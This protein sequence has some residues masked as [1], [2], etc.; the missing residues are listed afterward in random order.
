MHVIG[1]DIGTTGVKS[2]LLNEDGALEAEAT[3]GY[4]IHSPKTN[5]FE[6]NPEDWWAAAESSIRQILSSSGARRAKV[7]GIGL[8]GQY[9]GLVLLDKAGRLLRPCILWNDQRTHEEARE[10][11]EKVGGSR[12][13]EIACTRGA[14]YFTACKLLWVRKHEPELYARA[15]KMLLPKDYIRYRLTGE[16]ATDVS[17]ASGTIL[18]NVAR[19]KW[20]PELCGALDI[21]LNFLPAVH[22]SC[23]PT[24]Q[25]SASISRELGLD[26]G[27]LVVGGGGDQACAAVGNGITD[28]GIVGYSVGTSGVIYAATDEVKTDDG[29]RVD[30]FCHAVPGRWALLGVTNSAAAS[31][32]W[33]QQSF[34]AHERLEAER[35]KR[36]V[37]S[38]LEELAGS[39]RIG[40]DRLFF[41]PYL[42]GERHPHQDPNA[43]GA[44]I[45]LHS[46]HGLAHAARAVMEGVAY[47]FRDCLEI[48]RGL[49]VD[50]REIRGTGG[51]MKSRLWAE[52]Q[53]N[54]SGERLLLATTDEGGAAFGAAIL[55]LV[56]A[57]GYSSVQEAC[58]R[59]V[60]FDKEI[61]P[62]AE[63]KRSYE[64][65]FQFYRSLYP[66][67]RSRY[68]EL[69]ALP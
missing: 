65:Y 45:G 67:L 5:W 25:V 2:I 56:G 11:V 50:T 4:P 57:K 21:P 10:V 37:F 16:F 6:Q 69:S 12:L 64:K 63:M 33:F 8:S 38:I 27:V 19:R 39:V 30:T 46:G 48:M 36:S 49:G 60:R 3:A 26:S 43:R 58:R 35:Q 52:I 47:S 42:G 40:S 28:Q 13:M 55:A 20:S 66:S 9:H 7:A 31:L 44:F 68:A 62:D 24:G 17:D 54:V 34:A 29:G 15:A 53:A 22:E 59:L 1:L 41:L 18:L 23:E 61:K 32:A 51:G 14:L